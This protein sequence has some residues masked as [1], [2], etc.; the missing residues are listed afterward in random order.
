MSKAHPQEL[1]KYMEKVLTLKLNGN[2]KVTGTLRG[3][4]AFMNLVVDDSVKETKTGEKRN[5]GMAVI[6]SNSVILLESQERI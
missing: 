4:D 6:R 3:F 2:R 1:K 5:I